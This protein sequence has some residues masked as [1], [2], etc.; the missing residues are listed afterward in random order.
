[1]GSRIEHSVQT[2]CSPQRAWEIYTDSD[3]WRSW[4]GVYGDIRWVEGKPWTAGSRMEV[5]ML[6]PRAMTVKQVLTV[7][8]PQRKVAWHTGRA[9]ARDRRLGIGFHK[10]ALHAYSPYGR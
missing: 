2:R 8:E 1:M 3:R 6:Q 5:D 9:V 4:N 10:A 7:C